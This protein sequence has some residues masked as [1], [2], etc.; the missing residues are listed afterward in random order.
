MALRDHAKPLTINSRTMP[1]KS[2]KKSSKKRTP[3]AETTL[4]PHRSP[5]LTDLRESAKGGKLIDVQQYVSAGGSANVFVE[6]PLQQIYH[7]MVPDSLSALIG[8]RYMAPLITRVA[9]SKHSEAAASIQL[10][11]EAGAD[12]DAVANGTAS[13]I[14]ART[15]L[16]LCA[17][18]C[19]LSSVQALLQGSADADPC[20]QASSDGMS[21]LQFAAAHGR[22]DICRA[23]YTASSERVLELVGKSD[24]MI[25]TP[26][27]AACAMEQYAAVKL[28]CTLGADVNNTS[29]GTTAARRHQCE[30]G[31]WHRWVYSLDGRSTDR[32]CCSGYFTATEWC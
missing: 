7:E 19:N 11:L 12:A 20:Y 16:T 23:L 8:D 32:Q 2:S 4:V 5:N 3:A 27:I 21:A 15:A 14:L 10:L 31:W 17:I 13:G 28:L 9:G 1:K 26:L 30:Q 6:A 25:A 18:A 24:E 29:T 22:L